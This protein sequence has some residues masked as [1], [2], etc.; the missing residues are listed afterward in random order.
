MAGK[1]R[2]S[3]VIVLLTILVILTALTV[4]PRH[5]AAQSNSCTEAIG[6]CNY[7]FTTNGVTPSFVSAFALITNTMTVQTYS[8][9]SPGWVTLQYNPDVNMVCSN[10]GSTGNWVQGAIEY[11]VASG[12]PGG[13]SSTGYLYFTVWVFYP[14][15][16]PPEELWVNPPPYGPS[17]P[18]PWPLASNAQWYIAYEVSNGLISE[19]C[20]E[21]EIPIAYE[22]YDTLYTCISIP[23]QYTNRW[24]RSNVVW[25]GVSLLY[26]NETLVRGFVNFNPGGSGEFQF[27]SNVNLYQ[28][29]LANNTL[30]G[31]NVIYTQMYNQGTTCNMY[32][33]FQT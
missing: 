9:G 3:V 10:L 31:S 18:I 27:C 19:V 23:S 32:Q 16:S 2:I 11:Y 20:E 5:A 30:E 1:I 6:G 24:Y 22:V 21:V 13:P 4:L 14:C 26:P 8:G 15:T 17:E 7:E 12:Y 29:P 28:G 33:D 25:A